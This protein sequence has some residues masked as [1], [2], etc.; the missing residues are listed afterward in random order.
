[1]NSKNQLAYFSFFL[2]MIYQRYTKGR[3]KRMYI[4]SDNQLEISGYLAY[5]PHTLRKNILTADRE[6]LLEIRLRR[7]RPVVLIY[8]KERLFLAQEGGVTKNFQKGYIPTT[9]EIER[10][11]ENLFES[12]LYAHEDELEK[13]YITIKGGHRIGLCGELKNGRLRSF[14]D[15]T[16]LN[17]RIAHEHIGIAEPL[18]GDLIKNERVQST[19][20]ISPPMCGKTSLLRDI[21]RMLSTEGTKVGVCDTRGEIAS[22]YDGKPCM[23]VGDA[24]VLS[25][26]GK[27]SGM[28]MLLRTMSPEVI[29][30]DELGT[31]EDREAVSEIFGTGT[32]VIATAHCASR[33]ELENKGKLA[34]IANSFNLIVTLR[35]VGEIDEVYY[36]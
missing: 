35:G 19:L 5:L 30:C 3:N 34:G 6:G 21:T 7:N 27:A 4:L 23:D 17:F 26:S 28:S 12:S 10:L 18:R 9:R 11:L 31:G 33:K 13:G 36:V 8:Q 29:V 16:A 22:V 32:A 25:G 1:M 20:I 15:I 14:S 24:D 2:N